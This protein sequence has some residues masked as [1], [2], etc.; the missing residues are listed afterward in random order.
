MRRVPWQNG[1]KNGEGGVSGRFRVPFSAPR[2]SLEE[3]S[4]TPG[5]PLGH[6]RGAPGMLQDI[7]GCFERPKSTEETARAAPRDDS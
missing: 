5:P 2:G 1:E 4:G 3:A 7:L 6:P